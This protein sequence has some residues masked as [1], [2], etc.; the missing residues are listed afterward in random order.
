MDDD[1]VA[2]EQT[3]TQISKRLRELADAIDKDE[4][5]LVCLTIVA[6]VA[7]R[8]NGATGI[9]CDGHLHNGIEGEDLKSALGLVDDAWK[10]ILTAFATHG[11]DTVVRRNHVVN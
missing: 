3:P 2:E 7:D 11:A 6:L 4:H 1:L 8:T 10:K 9:I 5:S